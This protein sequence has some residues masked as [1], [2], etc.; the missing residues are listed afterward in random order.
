MRPQSKI[1]YRGP[2]MLDGAP[3]VA[4]ATVGSNDPLRDPHYQFH[5]SVEP[6]LKPGLTFAHQTRTVSTVGAR[7]ESG[8]EGIYTTR[9]LSH[10]ITQL[11]YEDVDEFPRYVYLV[12][13]KGPTEGSI[14]SAHQ[15]CNQ[16]SEVTVLALL[17]VLDDDPDG[18]TPD[19]GKIIWRA[20]KWIL[21]SSPS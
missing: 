9:Q 19:I 17:D 13:V 11:S 8:G 7:G 6:D 4:I 15:D 18:P 5:L 12:Y 3:I 20:Q 21:N 10:W 1:I 2:S 14:W 16:P